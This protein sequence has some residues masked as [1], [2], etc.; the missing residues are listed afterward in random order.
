MRVLD[1]LLYDDGVED[2]CASAAMYGVGDITV[3]F[4]SR[5]NCDNGVVSSLFK[6]KSNDRTRI[7]DIKTRRLHTLAT[8][9]CFDVMNIL[10]ITTPAGFPLS[11]IMDTVHLDRFMFLLR[12]MEAQ[13]R[14]IGLS[15]L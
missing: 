4:S 1:R 9:N 13:K 14:P 10:S 6:T 11:A 8:R 5:L 12:T 3:S 7:S 2:L 15:L